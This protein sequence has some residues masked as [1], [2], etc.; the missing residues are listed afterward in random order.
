MQEQLIQTKRTNNLIQ[1]LIS[2]GHVL[3]CVKT[4]HDPASEPDTN[5]GWR[6]G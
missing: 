5:V 2:A 1:V 3:F 4:Q 6:A